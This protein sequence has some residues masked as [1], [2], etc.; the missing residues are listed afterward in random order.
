MKPHSSDSSAVTAYKLMCE[1]HLERA[2]PFAEAAVAGAVVCT[3]IHGMLATILHGLGRREEAERVMLTA[4]QLDEG[5]ADAYDA[6][7]HAAIT[8]G[9][10]GRA[11]ALYRRAVEREPLTSRFWYNLASSARGL[12]HFAEAEAACNRSIVLDARAYS[13]YLLRSELRTQ[14]I[15]RNHVAELEA[16]LAG[17]SLDDRGRT[18]LG[19]ALAKEM[20]DLKRYDDAFRWY[21][22]A[23]SARRRRI[24]YDVGIDEKKIERILETYPSAH[25]RTPAA[26]YD[27]PRYIFVVGLP[28][29]GTTLL[30]RILTGLPQVR[31]NGETDNFSRALLSATPPGNEDVFS[32][33]ARADPVAVARGY[34]LRA[35]ASEKDA[36]VIEKLPLNYLYV[37]AIHRALPEAKILWIKRLPLDSCFAMYRTLFGQAYP[38]S[39]A[40]EDLARYFAAYDRLMCHWRSVLGG[41]LFEIN[42]EEL[43]TQ[44]ERIGAAVAGHCGLAWLASA[45]QIEENAAVSFTASASQVRRPIYTSSVG[46]WRH[47]AK[48]LE[49]LARRLS[50]LG[51][52]LHSAA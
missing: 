49:P 8:L 45:I 35:G 20:D 46:K 6:L 14:T 34:T 41:Q 39:Y 22:E 40:F 16:L 25:L 9:Q 51:V 31:T 1:G 10:P 33:A 47:Y 11:E 50:E 17:P 27:S 52:S 37:G 12:G 2:L 24:S 44:P 13:S 18:A 5:S 4:L 32:R 21:S 43:V 48:H 3:P 29:S 23:A 42:Y 38:F 7:A 30:E 15:D 19:Y 28:R 36:A 26:Q